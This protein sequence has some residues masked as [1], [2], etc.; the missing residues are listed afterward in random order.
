MLLC[1]FVFLYVLLSLYQ[2]HL[3]PL[4]FIAPGFNTEIV[5]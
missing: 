1:F 4:L 3:V 5:S 2:G